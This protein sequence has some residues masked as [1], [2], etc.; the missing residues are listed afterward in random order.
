MTQKSENSWDEKPSAQLK[1]G[2]ATLPPS[3]HYLMLEVEGY[4]CLLVDS[5]VKN[6][7]MSEAAAPLSGFCH[8]HPPTPSL[9]HW[10]ELQSDVLA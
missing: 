5:V 6:F 9:T 2:L 8:H 3:N 1:G 7:S 4:F 10:H